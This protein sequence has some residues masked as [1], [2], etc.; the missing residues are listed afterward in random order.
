ML[1]ETLSAAVRF[2]HIDNCHEDIPASNAQGSKMSVVFSVVTS[3]AYYSLARRSLVR[4]ILA[5]KR[6]SGY[7]RKESTIVM[8]QASGTHPAGYC[9]GLSV[10]QPNELDHFAPTLRGPSGGHC[11]EL[12]GW[13]K[14]G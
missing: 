9:G 1:T 3:R 14:N 7:A 11:V 5:L 8:S 2:N 4:S 6:I 12:E 10:A 13:P